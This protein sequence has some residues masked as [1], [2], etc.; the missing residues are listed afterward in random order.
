MGTTFLFMSMVLACEGGK[1]QDTDP[2][3][4]SAQEVVLDDTDLAALDFAWSVQSRP[5]MSGDEGVLDWSGLSADARGVA[6]EPATDVRRIVLVQ[7]QTLG[8]D[9][10]L[11]M[12]ATGELSQQSVTLQVDCSSKEGRCA[13]S[14]FRFEAGHP[15]DLGKTFLEGSG[16]WLAWVVDQDAG[17]PRA[18][19]QVEPNDSGPPEAV[20][21]DEDSDLSIVGWT[22]PTASVVLPADGAAIIRWSELSRNSQGG[23]L[24]PLRLDQGVLARVADGADMSSVL[25]DLPGRAEQS[26]AASLSG[27]QSLSLDA[28]T[29]SGGAAF[30]GFEGEGQW[31]LALSCSTCAGSQPAALFAIEPQ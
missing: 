7:F 25:L 8:L 1:G 21:T 30:A 28:F 20:W 24:S 12:L 19:L 17:E 29:D 16:T 15:I 4:T 10:I 27:V 22:E 14:E 18:L 13:L 2:G 26:Y 9:E 3:T 11:P 5:L 6:M 23:S 31:W